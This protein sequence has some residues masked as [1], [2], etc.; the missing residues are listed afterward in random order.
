MKER[1]WQQIR[2]RLEAKLNELDLSPAISPSSLDHILDTIVYPEFSHLLCD[3]QKQHWGVKRLDD[4]GN[5]FLISDQ[6][7]LE[8]AT[9][10][11]KAYEKKGHKQTYW[12]VRCQTS[13]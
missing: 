3:T 13:D 5:E 4:N 8:Q 9:A 12:A 6:H 10:I 2:Q 11:V 1:E 7:T